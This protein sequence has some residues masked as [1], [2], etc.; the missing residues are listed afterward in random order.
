VESNLLV[1]MNRKLDTLIKNTH[2][3]PTLAVIFPLGI[4]DSLM[5]TRCRL[6]FMCS[7]TRELVPCGDTEEKNGFIITATREWVKQ[8]A[9]AMQ[10][11]LNVLADK[12]GD[13]I[14][15]KLY[16][17]R[18]MLQA[19]LKGALNLVGSALS[20]KMSSTLHPKLNQEFASILMKDTVL[21]E[22]SR[23]AC[24]AMRSFLAGRDIVASTGLIQQTAGG[25]TAWIKNDPEVIKSFHHRKGRRLE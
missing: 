20:D 12:M 5:E 22:G 16:P 21:E 2:E 13:A 19:V 1:E 6:V 25:H 23:A 9:P 18:T 7:H 15:G 4:G 8:V 11:G 14:L 17:D 10:C 24:D 3:F